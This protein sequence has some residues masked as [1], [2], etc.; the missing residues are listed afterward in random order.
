MRP[1]LAILMTVSFCSQASAFSGLS[2]ITAW[3]VLWWPTE[4]SDVWDQ[5]SGGIGAGAG[6][7]W[8]IVETHGFLCS[9]STEC[10]YLMYD[11][12]EVRIPLGLASEGN[13]VDINNKY[14]LLLAGPG[15][16]LEYQKSSF[17]PY[18]EFSGGYIRYSNS[19]RLDNHRWIGEP[20]DRTLSMRKSSSYYAIGAGLKFLIW[21]SSRGE[22]EN[23]R[24]REVLLDLKSSLLKGGKATFL[25][26]NTTRLND[27]EVMNSIE[28]D[29]TEVDLSLYQFRLGVIVNL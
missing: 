20:F 11:P 8:H 16:M 12:E 7:S 19:Y 5:K 10:T 21:N 29:I 15:I 22:A 4:K 13:G 26:R 6:L 18:C 1:F 25:D 24:S 27:I 2:E 3:P 14:N 23:Q 28:Y 9:I 17:R